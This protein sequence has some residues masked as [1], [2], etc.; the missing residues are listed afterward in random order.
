MKK[1]DDFMVNKKYLNKELDFFKK[2]NMEIETIKY[3]KEFEK[4]LDSLFENSAEFGMTEK[5]YCCSS[6]DECCFEEIYEDGVWDLTKESTKIAIKNTVKSSRKYL[7][8]ARKYGRD[9][10]HV[11]SNNDTTYIYIY[12]RDKVLSDYL[13]WFAHNPIEYNY[14]KVDK[15]NIKNYIEET[16]ERA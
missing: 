11:L 1:E 6:L 2:E 7:Y 16:D 12:M 8:N 3:T 13:V 15:D 4:F 9:R 5:C 14:V 10:L